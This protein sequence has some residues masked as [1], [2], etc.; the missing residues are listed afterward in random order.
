MYRPRGR[1]QG[2]R[3]HQATVEGVAVRGG[4]GPHEGVSWKGEPLL[5]SAVLNVAGRRA[6]GQAVR[7]CVEA[8]GETMSRVR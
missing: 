6:H 8:D 2:T 3:I 4:D 1:I 7:R 5:A